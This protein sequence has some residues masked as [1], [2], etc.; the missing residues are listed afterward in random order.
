MVEDAIKLVVY[1]V[2]AGIIISFVAWGMDDL[3]MDY[4]RVKAG[5]EIDRMMAEIRVSGEVPGRMVVVSLNIP[6]EVHSVDFIP[7]LNA[8]TLVRIR[9]DGGSGVEKWYDGV[10][11]VADRGNV[12][13]WP[14]KGISIGPGK[15]NLKVRLIR[16]PFTGKVLS[17]VS[18]GYPVV[19]RITQVDAYG[20]E[21]RVKLISPESLSLANHSMEIYINGIRYPY[22]I[23]TLK[24]ENFDFSNHTGYQYTGGKAFSGVEWRNGEYGVINMKNGVIKPGDTVSVLLFENGRLVGRDE[25]RVQ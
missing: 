8:G 22:S 6:E 25:V 9:M 18:G 7:D 17:A 19:F 20:G 16:D 2:L 11:V 21:I 24:S 5:N 12:P 4:A 10:Y 3:N 1:T 15:D 23:T 14:L 13:L